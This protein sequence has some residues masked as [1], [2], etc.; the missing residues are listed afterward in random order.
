MF[1]FVSSVNTVSVNENEF[2]IIEIRLEEMISLSFVQKDH[3]RSL[4]YSIKSMVPHL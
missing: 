2:E 4:I 3:T 1:D